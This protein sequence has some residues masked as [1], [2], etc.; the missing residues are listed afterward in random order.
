MTLISIKDDNFNSLISLHLILVLLFKYLLI[1][2]KVVGTTLQ[3]N[4]FSIFG[5][6][7]LNIFKLLEIFEDQILL[8]EKFIFFIIFFWLL[9]KQTL[10]SEFPISPIKY[11]NY[12][13]LKKL[14]KLIF[15]IK[16]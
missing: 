12:L 14:S 11:I 7:L 1:N 13:F 3:N 15:K 16:Y 6:Y 8:F 2:L 10:I 9:I 4:I 5:K